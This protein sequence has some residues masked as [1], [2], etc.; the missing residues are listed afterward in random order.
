VFARIRSVDLLKKSPGNNTSSEPIGPNR[1]LLRYSTVSENE[2][3]T[4]ESS[5]YKVSI[6]R[7]AKARV[8]V[9]NP[10]SLS[11]LPNSCFF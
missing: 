4:A 10:V 6:F 3:T 1:R 11:N 5:L 2:E 9:S 7:T 8:A